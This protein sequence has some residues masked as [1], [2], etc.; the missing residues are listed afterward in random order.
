M[1]SPHRSRSR[2][3]PRHAPRRQSLPSAHCNNRICFRPQSRL[4]AGPS[5]DP[6]RVLY[7][8][9]CV[10]SFYYPFRRVPD[11]SASNLVPFPSISLRPLRPIIPPSRTPADDHRRPPCHHALLSAS[12]PPAR[13]R[14]PHPNPNPNPQIATIVHNDR[15]HFLFLSPSAPP[16]AHRSSP[17]CL[18]RFLPHP[19]PSTSQG[20]SDPA[21][22][23]P[24]SSF[25]RWPR[26]ARS[27]SPAIL[28][29]PRRLLP[30]LSLILIHLRSDA[31]HPER[32]SERRRGG[33]PSAGLNR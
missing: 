24:L 13:P 32:A 25:A 19:P 16:D 2:S 20:R 12:P 11:A 8:V 5:P 7:C 29:L 17:R 21:P 15:M 4:N 28:V 26:T 30:P 33:A 18:L 10:I 22:R 3:L 9:Y 14:T 6:I 27:S 1:P 23:P 31:A